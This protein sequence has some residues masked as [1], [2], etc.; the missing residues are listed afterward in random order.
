MKRIKLTQEKFAL[1]DDIDYEWL[2]QYKWS[3]HKNGARNWRQGFMHHLL[4]ERLPGFLNDH[5]DGDNLNNQR[6]NLRYATRREN[7]ANSKVQSD[8]KSGLKG[9]RLHGKKWQAYIYSGGHQINLGYYLTKE[10]A[11]LA[12]NK[13]AAKQFGTFARGNDL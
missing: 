8:N 4:L 6:Y 12:Y 9:V 5:E 7:R 1:V 3:L 10:K 2:N 11:A 13:A